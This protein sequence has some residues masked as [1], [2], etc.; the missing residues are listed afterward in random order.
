MHGVE[1]VGCHAHLVDLIRTEL[2]QNM[3]SNDSGI[4]TVERDEACK[5]LDYVD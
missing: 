4:V 3:V 1:S 5:F 2:I